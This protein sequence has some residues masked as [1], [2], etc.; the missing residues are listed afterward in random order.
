MVTTASATTA[1]PVTRG[2]RWERP[3]ECTIGNEDAGHER[4]DYACSHS[5]TPASKQIQKH[6]QLQ[7]RFHILA[8]D[9]YLEFPI[10]VD[11]RLEI[12]TTC[13]YKI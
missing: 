12:G 1:A 13:L 6:V 10:N 3:G 5:H 9:I 11:R 4:A 2:L 8:F 7:L